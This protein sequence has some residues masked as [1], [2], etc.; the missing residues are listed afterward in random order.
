MTAWVAVL[1]TAC[2]GI[3]GYVC[4]LMGSWTGTVLMHMEIGAL[5]SCMTVPVF[6]GVVWA[7]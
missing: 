4:R 5:G 3:R 6:V 1:G 7:G 2:F